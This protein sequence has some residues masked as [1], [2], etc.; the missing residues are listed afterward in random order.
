METKEAVK[1]KATP[2]PWHTGPNGVDI[3][4]GNEDPITIVFYNDDPEKA[5]AN[6]ALIAAAPELLEALK[7]AKVCLKENRGPSMDEFKQISAAIRK[8]EGRE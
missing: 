2:G 3:R 8:G 6:A 5:E 1:A 4:D 7:T